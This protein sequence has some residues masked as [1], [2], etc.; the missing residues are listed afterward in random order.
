MVSHIITA[1]VYQSATFEILLG[2]NSDVPLRCQTVAKG[3][4]MAN[5]GLLRLAEAERFFANF[6]SGVNF[7]NELKLPLAALISDTPR[8][9]RSDRVSSMSASA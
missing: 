5:A 9:A 8:Q 2:N 1:K 7:A 6:A 4:K 3:G